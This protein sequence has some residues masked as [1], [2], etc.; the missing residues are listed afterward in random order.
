MNIRHYLNMSVECVVWAELCVLLKWSNI[1]KYVFL[2]AVHYLEDMRYE[3]IVMFVL[4]LIELL[5]VGWVLSLAVC[6]HLVPHLGLLSCLGRAEG[7]KSRRVGGV[8]H[9]QTTGDRTPDPHND[10]SVP[11]HHRNTL[12]DVDLKVKN[13]W[14][15]QTNL[16]F[17]Q[18]HSSM[19]ESEM[20]G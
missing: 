7:W 18:R 13:S 15:K 20:N 4:F 9:T 12:P 10:Q 14:L 5:Q 8:S 1:L 2:S 16:G 11:P 19:M 3:S 17:R 6:S